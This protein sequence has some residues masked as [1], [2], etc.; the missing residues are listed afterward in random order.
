MELHIAHKDKEPLL[1]RMR[2]AGEVVFESKT[3]SSD[4]L[5]KS[6][7]TATKADEKLIVVKRI[8]TRFGM[9]KASFSAYVYEDEASMNAAEPK[10]KK[11]AEAVVK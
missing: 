9:R 4:E 1:S 5:R 8:G 3:P 7:A 6:L 11:K 10:P 2:I